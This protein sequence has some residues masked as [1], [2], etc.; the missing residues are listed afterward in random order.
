M[1]SVIERAAS[2]RV[3]VQ[4]WLM[5]WVLTAPLFHIHIP[6]STDRW[7]L[8]RSGGV[9]TVLSPDLPGEFAAQFAAD[10]YSTHLS[11]R[12]VHSPELGIA[13]SDEKY[14][15]RSPQSD[16]LAGASWPF[17]D[18]VSSASDVS[19]TVTGYNASSLARPSPRAPPSTLQPIS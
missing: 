15:N 5:V 12:A 10:E 19:L 17:H 2:L 18:C 3:L 8:L 9:H 11:Q 13:L 16:I 4:A 14:N 7:S 6:D 1:R